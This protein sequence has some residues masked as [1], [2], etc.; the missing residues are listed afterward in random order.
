MGE[1]QSAQGGFGAAAQSDLRQSLRSV[2]PAGVGQALPS[3]SRE[4]P[5]VAPAAAA[6]AGFLLGGGLTPR[7]LA[8]AARLL[9]RSYARGIV[10]QALHDMVGEQ[11]FA[12][13]R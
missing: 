3:F 8:T 7:L 11:L 2:N 6:T 1:E 12:E 5:H 4:N 10:T 9:T 13:R